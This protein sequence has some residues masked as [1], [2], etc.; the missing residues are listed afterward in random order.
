MTNLLIFISIT[1]SVEYSA[2]L[3]EKAN[4]PIFI[5]MTHLA[6]GLCGPDGA[7]IDGAPCGPNWNDPSATFHRTVAIGKGLVGTN[8][9]D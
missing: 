3:S 7:T 5:E 1:L 9:S 6:G 4:S 2:R 8:Q